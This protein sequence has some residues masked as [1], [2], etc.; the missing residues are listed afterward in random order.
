MELTLKDLL[1]FDLAGGSLE[2]HLK[3]LVLFCP[4]Q[5]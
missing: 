5:N 1:L 4:G 2:G 3:I